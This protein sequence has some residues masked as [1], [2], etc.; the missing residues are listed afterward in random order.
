MGIFKKFW[1]LI[2]G[3]F[4]GII[5]VIAMMKKSSGKETSDMIRVENEEALKPIKK[6]LKDLGKKAHQLEKE[7]ID[8][9]KESDV[10][11]LDSD[12]VVDYWEDKL[13]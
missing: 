10:E 4:L 2:V 9:E 3:L 1:Q 7:L 8:L 6:N 13:K 5:S 11:E 12:G